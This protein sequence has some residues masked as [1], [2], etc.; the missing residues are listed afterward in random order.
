M[1]ARIFPIGVQDFEKIRKD[2]Y[3]YIDK[4]A[5]VYQLAKTG[6][7]YFLS[8][9]R[10]FGKSLL[11]STLETYFRGKKELFKG[12]AIEKLEKDWEEYPVLHLDLN[13]GLYDSAERLLFVLED[14][15]HRW[16]NLYG[17]SVSEKT[18]ELRFMGVIRRAYER[19]GSRVVIL[20]DEYDKPLLQ[21][22]GNPELQEKYRSILKAFYGV[23]K[24]MDG[25]IKFAL[26]TGV[27]KF[28]KVSVFS[29]LNNLDDLTMRLMLPFAG[30]RRRSCVPVLMRISIRSL[31][32]LSSPMRKPALRWPC[33][34]MATI[35]RKIAWGSIT[36]SAC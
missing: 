32:R 21:A 26:L 34:T 24:T 9:P 25:S 20:V 29:D 23:L 5:L 33:I 8:R 28:G 16:E 2:G 22:I 36:L 17:T 3:L 1:S 18:P 30:S 27:T 12:L 13:T 35:L 10:R 15:L 7:Y 11:I 31:W 19:T 6:S 14:A 4:T